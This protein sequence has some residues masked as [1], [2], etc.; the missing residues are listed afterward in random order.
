[1]LC[2]LRLYDKDCTLGILAIQLVTGTIKKMFRGTS[3]R[4]WIQRAV[5]YLCLS[6]CSLEPLPTSSQD[7]NYLFRMVQI[8]YISTLSNNEVIILRVVNSET[9][10][11]IFPAGEEEKCALHNKYVIFWAFGCRKAM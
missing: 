4:M 6:V 10:A 5:T 3:I 11:R 1:M 2:V 7:Q 8:M 9:V